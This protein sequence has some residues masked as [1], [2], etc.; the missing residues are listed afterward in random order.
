MK[1]IFLFIAL[2]TFISCTH[3]STSRRPQS[4]NIINAPIDTVWEKTLQ[5]LPTE[6]ITIKLADKNSYS[7]LG[8]KG[9]SLWSIADDITIQ[10]IPKGENQTIVNFSS[11]TKNLVIGWGH[12]ERMVLN[13]FERIK[14]LS[15]Q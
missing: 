6:N 9:M 3:Y 2:I 7:V 15:E 11:E 5:V 10:L 1:K 12:E 13:V 14:E 8:R 4:E